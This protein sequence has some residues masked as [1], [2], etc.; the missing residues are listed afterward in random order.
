MYEKLAEAI[1]R[2]NERESK[3][4]LLHLFQEAAVAEQVPDEQ[5]LARRMRRMYEDLICLQPEQ[6]LTEAALNHWH[7]VFGDSAAGSLKFGLSS[8]KAWRRQVVTVST[9]LSVGPLIRLNDAHDLHRR[10][11]WMKE[12]FNG[13]FFDEDSNAALIDQLNAIKA[14]PEQVPITIW[15]SDNAWEQCGL[16][17]VVCLLRSRTNPI[18]VINPSDFEK[19]RLEMFGEGTLTAYSG[20]LAPETLAMLYKKKV[21]DPPLTVNERNRLENEWLRLSR[22]PSELRIWVDGRVQPAAP[23]Y[24]D[25]EILRLARRLSRQPEHR[26]GFLCLRLIGE[27]IGELQEKQWVSDV[28]IFWRIRKLIEAGKLTTGAPPGQ[29]LHARLTVHKN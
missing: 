23:D 5:R 7:I 16:C 19:K 22:A 20:Q 6:P 1:S 13:Y 14:I 24:F 28:F 18:Q 27:A 12:N 4:M 21:Q 17:L 15:A 25:A 10:T 2:L 26:N 8:M 9:D 11:T 29:I 3:W